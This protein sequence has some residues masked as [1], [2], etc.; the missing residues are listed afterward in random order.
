MNDLF[1]FAA[2][3]TLTGATAATLLATNVIGGLI[4]PSGDKARKWIALGIALA[5][6]YVT[7][8]FADDAGP[9]KWIVAFFNGL[10]IFS[11]ALGVNQ[12]PPGNRQATSASPTQLAQGREPRYLRSW[13]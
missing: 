2:L 6:S 7:A 4:G 5:L 13:V 1:T 9:E 11:A 12:L 10:V 3:G 8:A